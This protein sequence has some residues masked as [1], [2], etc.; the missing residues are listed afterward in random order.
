MDTPVIV[1]DPAVMLGK[2][3][4]AGTRVTVELVLEKLAAGEPPE[5]IAR[6]HPHLPPGAIPAALRYA[7]AAIRNEVV[8]PLG[9]AA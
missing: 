3:V 6:A 8:V 2:P 5:Q 4:F 7:A 1:T 9:R